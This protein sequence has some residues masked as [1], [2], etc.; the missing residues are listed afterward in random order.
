MGVVV[1]AGNSFP[2]IDSGSTG[3]VGRRELEGGIA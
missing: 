3:A 1:V 2:G